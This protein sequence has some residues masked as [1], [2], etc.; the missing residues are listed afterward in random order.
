MNPDVHSEMPW[1]G[2]GIAFSRMAFECRMTEYRAY[3]FTSYGGPEQQEYLTLPL[4]QAGPGQLLVEVRAA[5]VN[6]GDWK[7]RS[8]QAAKP[9]A[10]GVP[11]AAD[12]PGV[13]GREAAGIVRAVGPGVTGF[14][15]GDEVFGTTDPAFGG[16]AEFT[17]LAAAQTA[18]KPPQVGFEQAS[19]LTVAAGTAH[20]ALHALDL[21]K[22]RT[23]LVNGVGGGVGVAVAQLARA[24]GITVVGTAGERKRSLVESFGVTLVPRGE[25][26][27]ERLRRQL[28]QGTADALIDLV[29]GDS[30]RELATLVTDRA[31][32]LSCADKPLAA[33]LGGGEVPRR[34]TTAVYAEVARLVADGELDPQVTVLP[35]AEAGAALAEVE[36]GHAQGK[37]ALRIS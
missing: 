33:E 3:G 17:V 7:V 29:G 24:R 12:L 11:S 35:F 18:H 27:V 8:G 28:P 15:V 6:P 32:L 22:G 5:G 16:Y 20:D 19:V 14:A 25:G 1:H 13:L 2:V 30:L 21:E 9:S 4:P 26:V 34:R 10:T 23:L 36:A 31:R 37:I